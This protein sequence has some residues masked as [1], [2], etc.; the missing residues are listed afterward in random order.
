[1]EKRFLLWSLLTCLGFSWGYPQQNSP[2]SL[3]Y[4][5]G[6]EDSDMDVWHVYNG[7]GSANRW[8]V[9]SAVNHGGMRSLYITDD[10]VNKPHA[11]DVENF[12]LSVAYVDIQFG[13][14][15]SYEVSFD[16]IGQGE[17]NY[18]V[19]WIGMQDPD[20]DFPSFFNINRLPQN[21]LPFPDENNVLTIDDYLYG[22]TWKTVRF[23]IDSNGIANRVKRIFFVW[24]NDMG[25]GTNPPIAIDNFSIK[26][27]SCVAMAPEQISI[28]LQMPTLSIGF[29]DNSI[30]SVARIT[31]ISGH[32]ADTQFVETAFPCSVNV[33]PK[34]N[35][36]VFVEKICAVGDT[37]VATIKTIKTPCLPAPLPFVEDFNG[38]GD[39]DAVWSILSGDDACWSRKKK[40]FTDTVDMN[41]AYS[42][43][44][45]PANLSTL[46]GMST[47]HV[48]S[49]MNG[50]YSALNEWLISPSI[51]LGNSQDPRQISFDVMITGSSFQ[52]TPPMAG[53]LNGVRFAVAFSTDGGN[54]WLKSRAYIWDT[55][56]SAYGNIT[57]FDER[58]RRITLPIVDENALPMTGHVSFAF[59]LEVPLGNSNENFLRIDDIAVEPY[60]SCPLPRSFNVDSIYAHEAWLFIDPATGT[61]SW[62][63]EIEELN[64]NFQGSYTSVTGT[65]VVELSDLLSGT[66]YKLRIRTLCGSVENS[67]W[68]D[69]VSFRTAP[70]PVSV[71]FMLDFE[72]AFANHSVG[73]LSKGKNHWIIDTAT[74]EFG[75][76]SLYIASEDSLNKYFYDVHSASVA[77]AYMDL[78]VDNGD[79]YELAFDWKAMGENYGTVAYDFMKV[80]FQEVTDPL[81]SRQ[82][83][84]DARSLVFN[85]K[86]TL[87][88]SEEWNTAHTEIPAVVAPNGIKRLVF[89]WS[90]DAGMGTQPP[91]AVDNISFS[92]MICPSA[93]NLGT[94]SVT[95]TT[96]VLTWSNVS[97]EAYEL[98]YGM[99]VYGDTAFLIHEVVNDTSCTLSNLTP[100]TAYF[101]YVTSMCQE[102]NGRVSNLLH[103][104]TK[105]LP[106]EVPYICDFEP[107]SDI[108]P[109]MFHTEDGTDEWI[110]DAAVA[111][112]G[113][114]SLYVTNNGYDYAYGDNSLTYAY[115]DVVFSP[116]SEHIM[117][118][119]WKCKGEGRWD[120]LKVLMQD[121]SEPLPFNLTPDEEAIVLNENKRYLSG[122]TAWH[123][124]SV[125]LDSSVSNKNK[126]IIFV[127]KSDR[128]NHSSTPASIDNF[129]LIPSGCP[130]TTI[131]V[132]HITHESATVNIAGIS[133][134]EG[135]VMD[136]A[137]NDSLITQEY[138]DSTAY[139]IFGLEPSTRY[140]ISVRSLCSATDTS[141][142]SNIVNIV[143]DCAVEPVP[144]FNTFSSLPTC[145]QR[146][147]AR[148][149][150]GIITDE[151]EDTHPTE[152]WRSETIDGHDHVAG[153]IYGTDEY[154]WLISPTLRMNPDENNELAFNMWLTAFGQS[155]SPDTVSKDSKFMI[156]VSTDAGYTWDT[157]NAVIWDMDSN[158]FECSRLS[159]ITNTPT[160]Y[161][162]PMGHYSGLVKVAFYIES[163]ISGYDD[164][165][166]HID[167]VFI[168]VREDYECVA[169]ERVTAEN[170]T[171][172][173][174]TIAWVEN[175]TATAW[176]IDCNGMLTTIN[177]N[178]YTLTGLTANTTYI[179]KVKSICDSNHA[180]EWS[181]ILQFTTET[182]V[183]LSS[184]S[185]ME[186][187][188]ITTTSANLRARLSRG[189]DNITEG[190]FEWKEASNREYTVVSA[191]HPIVSTFTHKLTNLT[192]ETLY[193]YRAYI[194]VNGEKRYGEEKNFS[195]DRVGMED[196]D[197]KFQVCLFPNPATE[198]VAIDF[199][200][201]KGSVAWTLVDMNGRIVEKGDTYLQ[202]KHNAM[203]I[204]VSHLPEGI[205]YFQVQSSNG[206]FTRKLV[207]Q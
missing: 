7:T 72:D 162:L 115:V 100:S 108:A 190:G 36:S 101:A 52:A 73:L 140:S 136:V 87:N 15:T 189:N 167:S 129:A 204:D 48:Y 134:A 193:I 18:D 5:T 26:E 10:T 78:L 98:T 23:S 138:T 168:G 85:G 3:P 22:G 41:G 17:R 181:S 90:N 152:G 8:V 205:Y 161:R 142:R 83:A 165:E 58:V 183:I 110:V 128:L 89:A 124:A 27:T 43:N 186:A 153:N 105:A 188:D 123:Q 151:M 59:Y 74:A 125:I 139:T 178:P 120:F 66:V 192:P 146:K 172:T 70:E 68:S 137:I 170:I 61:S 163:S 1:M 121:V 64:N 133:S 62:E 141:V 197:E 53:S 32:E 40:L 184:V 112:D 169:P 149:H 54:T 63:Y 127:W 122:D 99:V 157:N 94:D 13:Y 39:D 158:H 154:Y 45:W 9:G 166:L 104:R 93:K 155:Q 179:I 97:T 198:L 173:S 33:S 195:T 67:A 56:G 203:T 60:V 47:N 102:G 199:Q 132:S 187:F 113:D 81:P 2:I 28:G 96:A 207:I 44:W 55:S 20:D 145:W 150:H 25:G 200:D 88:G 42:S 202:G 84:P 77:L 71:P 75:N 38:G 174:A 114:Y 31:L 164:V 126:R 176:E 111:K 117:S 180:S 46:D 29:T 30:L 79:T 50:E 37:S 14:A 116:A 107:T 177:T 91:A 80:F 86:N 194:M 95:A 148:F 159:S 34:T 69:S 4:A 76:Y 49:C 171:N 11:Y 118:F 175:G 143:T 106:V 109:W 92:K 103:F 6:F 82:I 21:M 185:T 35:Y 191:A 196:I 12:A 147:E 51:D 156:L 144:Y 160:T 201:A 206:V 24:S 119:D 135:W 19:A 16:W 182:P 57:T 65:S 131:E 130:S